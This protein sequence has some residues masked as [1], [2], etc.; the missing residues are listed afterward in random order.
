MK[1]RRINPP[2]H[3]LRTF[4]TVVRFGGISRAAN[5]LKLT[6]GAITKQV[7]DLERWLELPLFQRNGKKLDLTVAGSRY[8][9][10]IRPLLEQLE[11]ATLELISQGIHAAALNI[12][13][14]PTFC[15]KWLIPRLP[16]FYHQHPDVQINFVRYVNSVD[17]RDS[18]IDGSILFG[19]GKWPGAQAIYLDGRD[20]VLVAPPQAAGSIHEA[21]D[22]GR[23]ALL[24]HVTVPQHWPLWAELNQLP[25]LRTLTGP[26]FDNYHA[27]IQAVVSGLGVALLPRCLVADELANGVLIAPLAGQPG[28][29]Y[30]ATAG[31]WFCFETDR[32]HT[33]AL[34]HFTNWLAGQVDD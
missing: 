25:E 22:V 31:Y 24:R 8:E 33:V 11:D 27:M 30:T 13:A 20:V 7:Q 18:S 14:M 26:Q 10:R 29:G 21:A 32:G 15:T 3:L 6:Q 9:R 12:S 1:I 2:S 34:T 5:E 4:S 28:G 23:F 19:D 17:F 16:D